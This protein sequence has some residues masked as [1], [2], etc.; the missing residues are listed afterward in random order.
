[1]PNKRGK[2]SL[3]FGPPAEG[4]ELFR[5]HSL[6]VL[7]IECINHSGS[8]GVETV[9]SS[10]LRMSGLLNREVCASLD[11]LVALEEGINT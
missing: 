11:I 3:S 4:I 9:G 1:M 5:K 2:G 7:R 8:E 6:D 10:M